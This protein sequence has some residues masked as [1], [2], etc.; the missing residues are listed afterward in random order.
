MG[1]YLGTKAVHSRTILLTGTVYK[2]SKVTTISQ[3]WHDFSDATDTT[4]FRKWPDPS[5]PSGDKTLSYRHF[6]F[7]YSYIYTGGGGYSI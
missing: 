3:L 4:Y 7:F 6:L 1:Y 2:V 5:N